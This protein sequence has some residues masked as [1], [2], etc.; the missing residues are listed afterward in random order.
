MT[1]EESV[2]PERDSRPEVVPL[3]WIQYQ[4]DNCATVDEV[5]AT[6]KVIRVARWEAAPR[7]HHFFVSDSTGKSATLEFVGA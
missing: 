3:Q 1:L 6:D 2:Y 7:G 5:L 4:L